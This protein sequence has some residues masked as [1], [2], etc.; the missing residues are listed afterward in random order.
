ML[1][2]CDV[3]VLKLQDCDEKVTVGGYGISGKLMP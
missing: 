3:E 2:C 1:R